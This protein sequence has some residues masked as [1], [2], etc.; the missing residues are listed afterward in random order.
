M[1][2]VVV[3]CNQRCD[4]DNQPIS[5]NVK[6]R[7]IYGLSNLHTSLLLRFLFQMRGKVKRYKV[8]LINNSPIFSFEK[9]TEPY[10]YYY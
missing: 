1:T 3:L 9:T 6:L 2:H 5:L 10:N 8:R 7:Y 4:L